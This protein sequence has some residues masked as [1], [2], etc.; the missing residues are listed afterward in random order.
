M[1]NTLEVYPVKERNTVEIPMSSGADSGVY[2]LDPPA[3]TR[4][5][6]TK[7][8]PLSYAQ[9]RLWL[10]DQLTPHT[11]AHNLPLALRLRGELHHEALERS[12]SEIVRRHEAL[13]TT[14][15]VR[16]EEV[17]QIV[18]PAEPIHLHPL[19]L[20]RVPAAHREEEWRQLV[21]QF[22]ERP[23]DLRRGPLVRF[24]LLQVEEDEHVLLISMHH[25]VSDAW[26][27][28]VLLREWTALYS[29]F[30]EGRPSPLDELPIQYADYAHW[31]RNGLEVGVL[32]EQLNYWQ[33]HLGGDRPF[34]QLPTDRP[35][36]AVQT[37]RGGSVTFTLSEK[38]AEGLKTL[39]HRLGAT[40]FMTMLSAFQTLLSRYSGQ[41]D[42]WVGTPMVGRHQQETEG[43]I[44][45]FANTLVLRGDLSRD[46]TFA[47][48]I[49]RT[50]ET[51]LG[52]HAHQDVPLEKLVEV[53]HPE[54]DFSLSS[55][56]QVMFVL[57]NNPVPDLA[58]PGMEV[59]SVELPFAIAKF[60]L[61]LVMIEGADGL[62]GSIEYNTDLFDRETILRMVGH[63]ETLLSAVVAD[64]Q[65]RISQLPLLTAGEREQLLHGWNQ[66]Q[67]EVPTANCLHELFDLQVEETPDAVAVRFQNQS[68]TYHELNARANR[69]AHDLQQ[70]GVGREVLVGILME[71][72][73]EFLVAML[74]IFKAGGACLP[75]DPAHPSSRIAHILTH[76]QAPLVLTSP[77]LEEKLD[78][79]GAQVICVETEA[80]A[81]ADCSQ[82]NTAPTVTPD[83]LAY[84]LYTSSS[85]GLSKGA[86]LEQKG[87]INHLFVKILDL[88]LGPDDIVAQTASPSFDISVWQFLA[89][90]LTGGCVHIFDSETTD[91][92]AKLI[93]QVARNGITVWETVPSMLRAVLAEVVQA[94]E[95]DL[96]HL[97]Y[98]ITTGESLSPELARQWLHINPNIPLV[99][100]YGVTECSDKVT[101]EKVLTAP[102]ESVMKMSIGRP[103]ANMRLYLLDQH[104]SP[105]P[106]GVA[107]E[108][109]IG[110][111]GVG[112][113]YLNEPDLTAQSFFPNP[114]VEK[115]GARLYKTGDLARYLPD[116]RL[117]FLGRLELGKM[118]TGWE[119]APSC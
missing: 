25:I 74:G 49:D 30:S 88:E 50:R 29:A 40:L 58:V 45:R 28:S 47:E 52:A 14:F 32:N 2:N 100:A 37:H 61:T 1:I 81:I 77:E 17:V 99:N 83:S 93:Q 109:Y 80:E 62:S 97:R 54:R 36:P 12:L 21:Q 60:D 8:S 86:M 55:L 44:G 56:F 92:P 42:L 118:E 75:L 59:E 101:H 119:Q 51:V 84:V 111:I 94:V 116:G 114:F 82:E 10:L 6:R 69:L 66:T 112:R 103:V 104:L 67:V 91:D 35:Q 76:A 9:Q 15:A 27:I 34:L 24:Y 11:A 26:S 43:L 108:M 65:R 71:R 3:I 85:T 70:R 68:L 48:L 113:G 72:S 79:C 105:V 107:G 78:G 4:F 39:S 87:M 16:N 102:E 90:L 95:L 53:L 38:V 33:Q 46:P 96:S 41:H 89:V 31:Q 117:E 110:G 115:A 22:A 63:F 106:I 73:V 18:G 57:Q 20:R 64:P 23:F 98:V 5:E 19:D 13:R 7:P